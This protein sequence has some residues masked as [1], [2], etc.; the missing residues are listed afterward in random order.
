MA[1][2]TSS[3]PRPAPQPEPVRQPPGIQHQTQSHPAPSHVGKDK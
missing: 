3:A 2:S 1:K